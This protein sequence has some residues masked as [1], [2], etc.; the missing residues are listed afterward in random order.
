MSMNFTPPW[1]A[2]SPHIQTMLPLLAA[3]ASLSL[4]RQRLELADGDFIDLDWL[5]YDRR[6]QGVLLLLHGLEGNSQSHY[7][8]RVLHQC[9][10]LGRCAVVHHHRSCSGEPNRL[11]R[12]YHSGDT[13]DLRHTLAHIRQQSRS[14]NLYACGYSLGG[15][16]LAKYLGEAGRDS[17]ITR[18]V[19]VSAPLHLAACA[20]RL[21]RGFSRVYQAHL[22]KR[23]RHKTQQ[24]IS[25]HALAMTIKQVQTLTN[26]YQFD[27]QVTAPLH[28]FAS[29]DDYYQRASGIGFLDTI[30][31]PTLIVHAQDDPF[32]TAAVIPTNTQLSKH[33]QYELHPHGGHVGF[34]NGGTP[35][36]P[37]FY[38]EKRILSFLP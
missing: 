37:T 18:A 28:G 26:F 12:S 11:A 10:R 23:L 7:I 3:P 6:H 30:T 20:Q 36:K 31:T 17:Q 34:I 19:V 29:A 24:K 35:W 38:L 5:N 9:Q 25:Q 13:Y 33:V 21:Q 32:M 2:K 8:K 15:N 14:T 22:L 27:H 1:W 16:M 4:M